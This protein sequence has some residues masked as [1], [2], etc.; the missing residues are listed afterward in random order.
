MPRSALASWPE[1]FHEIWV[2]EDS[3]SCSKVTV[4]LTLESPRRTATVHVVLVFAMRRMEAYA[5]LCGL[6]FL[7]GWTRR[8]GG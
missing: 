1:M 7:L 5:V 6:V 4:P 3:F 2:G 8:G